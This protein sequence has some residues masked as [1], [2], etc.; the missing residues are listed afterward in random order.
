MRVTSESRAAWLGEGPAGARNPPVGGV[1]SCSVSLVCPVLNRIQGKMT[2]SNSSWRDGLLAFMEINT[3]TSKTGTPSSV[4]S[5]P[6]ICR[7]RVSSL[8][9]L[10]PLRNSSPQLSSVPRT[11]C[12][13][14][15]HCRVWGPG[16]MKSPIDPPASYLANVCSAEPRSLCS[17]GALALCFLNQRGVLKEPLTLEVLSVRSSLHPPQGK[18]PKS[19]QA[20]MVLKVMGYSRTLS[21]EQLGG[22]FPLKQRFTPFACMLHQSTYVCLVGTSQDLGG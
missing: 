1:A 18:L 5:C 17:T 22:R 10:L 13:Q 11:S 16:C 12:T 8:Q 15:Q 2:L 4:R 3:S 6:A 20:L 14:A 21:P 7:L 9:F 19:T